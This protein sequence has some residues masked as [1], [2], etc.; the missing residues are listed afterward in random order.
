MARAP[1]SC[2][3]IFAAGVLL[4]S[5]WEDWGGWGY[6]TRMLTDL[7]PYAILLLIPVYAQMQLA[8]QEALFVMTAYAMVVHSFALWDYGVRWH[9]HGELSLRRLGMARE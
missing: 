9:W 6:G 3:A 8:W 7:L 1:R 2:A 5:M 4:L